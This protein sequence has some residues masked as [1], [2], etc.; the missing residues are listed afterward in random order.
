MSLSAIYLRQLL[1]GN[2]LL[3]KVCLYGEKFVPVMRFADNEAHEKTKLR[4]Y[5]SF[6]TVLFIIVP[7]AVNTLGGGGNQ[8]RSSI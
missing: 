3:K 8:F 4:N 6:L 5:V 2:N 7:S 1:L